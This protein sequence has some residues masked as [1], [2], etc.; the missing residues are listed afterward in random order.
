MRFVDYFFL[1]L[2]VLILIEIIV[3]VIWRI[4][5]FFKKSCK[6]KKCPYR[7]EYHLS[8]HFGWLEKGC[9]KF[10]PT[11]EE[12]DENERMLDQLEQLIEQLK[13]ENKDKD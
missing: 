7:H 3:V 12:I 2:Y 11:Q 13:E 6:W 4:T 8:R 9:D 10:P 5:C 1:V